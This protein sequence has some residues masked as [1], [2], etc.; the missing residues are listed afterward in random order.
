MIYLRT[1]DHE[2]NEHAARLRC[3]PGYNKV[4][5]GIPA[6]VNKLTVSRR[7]DNCAATLLP[8]KL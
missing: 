8:D 7:A 1:T 3:Q 6:R 2:T 4:H 5:R